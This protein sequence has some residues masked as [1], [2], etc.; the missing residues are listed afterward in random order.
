MSEAGVDEIR[1]GNRT[2]LRFYGFPTRSAE[3]Q[4]E[5]W[6]FLRH[7]VPNNYDDRRRWNIIGMASRLR[8]RESADPELN[9]DLSRRRARAIEN[10]ILTVLFD[11]MRRRGARG[12]IMPNL[13][14]S[15][16]GVGTQWSD[17]PDSQVNDPG[18][19]AV[20]LVAGPEVRQGQ[21]IRVTPSVPG[22][23]PMREFWIKYCGGGS[24]SLIVP[25]GTMALI[26]IRDSNHYYQRYFYG[27]IGLG[28]SAPISFGDALPP[29]Q[30]WVRF[31]T[32]DAYR[33]DSFS[34]AA[35]VSGGGVQVADASLSI[36]AL[37][38]GYGRGPSRLPLSVDLP[39]GT[40]F[41]L[42]AGSDLVGRLFIGDMEVERGNGWRY[43]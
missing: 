27:G 34:G 20:L 5:H 4:P 8:F 33:V 28:V 3:V 1:V 29:G 38:F 12:L 25:D 15:V 13:D 14:T 22:F 24:A 9:T 43:L 36:L 2:A 18:H 26:A 42:G 41:T 19:R 10:A 39:T 35:Q 11:E 32:S 37:T 30:G 6:A 40:G 7:W 31:M 17:D 21:T 16:Q 23:A